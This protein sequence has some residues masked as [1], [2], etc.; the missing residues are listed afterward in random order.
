MDGI[1]WSWAE[2]VNQKEMNDEKYSLG[3]DDEIDPNQNNV[4][5]V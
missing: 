5:N 4:F 3:K 2:E 1:I